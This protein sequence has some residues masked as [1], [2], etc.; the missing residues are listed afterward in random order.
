VV[1]VRQVESPQ[2]EAQGKKRFV[3]FC[4]GCKC[5]HHFRTGPGEWTFNGDMEKPTVSPSLLLTAPGDPNYRCHSFVR[6]GMI[7]FL[8][9][10][11]HALKGQTVPLED[12]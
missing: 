10:C 5:G 12:F 4:P 2:E 1:K 3:V 8:S 6:D 7:Q 11:N 9:D